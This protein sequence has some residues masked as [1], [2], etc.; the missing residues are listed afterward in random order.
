MKTVLID[1]DGV[2]AD[3]DRSVFEILKSEYPDV[4][5]NYD[6]LNFYMVN[7]YSNK[8]VKEIVRSIPERANFFLTL[9]IMPNALQG[10]QRIIDLGYHPRICSSPLKSNLTCGKDKLRWLQNNL[11]AHFGQDIVTE[12]IITSD[13][14]LSDGLAL[15]DDKSAIKNAAE[16]TWT[17][18]VFHHP[19]NANIET[20]FRIK[21][22]LDERLPEL[23]ERTENNYGK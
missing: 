5:I 6:R 18:I 2:L 14:Y 3:F 11:A 16:A 4:K 12:A 8:K 10:V 15:I 17:Q 22:W 9:P 7:D 23:L 1:M 21:D 19:Y 13:K 20:E